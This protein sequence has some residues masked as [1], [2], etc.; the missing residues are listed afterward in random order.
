M[1]KIQFASGRQSLCALTLD[2]IAGNI[3]LPESTTYYFWLQARNDC[4]Y[5]LPGPVSNISIFENSGIKVTIPEQAL[6]SGENWLQYIILVADTNDIT[7]ANVLLVIEN[8]NLVFPYEINLTE[9]V[10]LETPRVLT[11]APTTNLVNGLVYSES[12]SGNIFFYSSL[13]NTWKRHY[14]GFNTGI[15]QTTEDL[16]LGCDTALIDIAPSRYIIN[17]DYPMNGQKGKSRKYWI[18]NNSSN[19]LEVD[20][21]LGITT[22]IQDQDV[23]SLFYGLFKV[24]FEG[25]FDRVTNQYVDDFTFS[26]INVEQSYES[27]MQ[28]LILEKELLP[29]QAFQ[30]SV[31]PEFN[32][33]ELG[34]AK[35]LLPADSSINLVPFLIPNT[36]R[37]TDLGILLGDSIVG[38]DS[39]LRRVYPAVGLSAFVD[40]G[41]T[42]IDGVLAKTTAPTLV[43]GFQSEQENQILAINSSGSLYSLSSGSTLRV[44]ERQR[45][46]VSTLA[47]E[48]KVSTF[49]SQI[50]ANTNP[51]ININITY[52]TLIRANYPDVISGSDKG[53]FNAEEIVFY[54]RKRES[55]D[56]TVI[57]TRRMGGFLPTNTISDSFEFLYEDAVI[58]TAALPSVDFGFYEPEQLLLEDVQL[59]NTIGGFFFDIAVSFKYN[60]TTLSSI[61]H[62]GNS[63]VELL[64]PLNEMADQL[65][66]WQKPVLTLSAMQNLPLSNLVNLAIYPVVETSKFYMYLANSTEVIDNVNIFGAT[67]DNGTGRFKSFS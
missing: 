28:N 19:E 36:G 46:L 60:G 4:G 50:E 29:Q 23:S 47:G 67:N 39:N 41:V 40:T 65:K 24:V 55:L 51:V 25:Y 64:K 7:Q 57:E 2:A 15:I 52:P 32:E 5:N 66:Y 58:Y 35:N 53:E 49:S 27:S 22:T 3:T 13:S 9:N 59:T 33:N 45:A 62:G 43:V 20:R 26:F 37:P 14:E 12:S 18:F 42:I 63:I 31:F 16:L 34:L 48:S 61:S 38:I 44:N 54:V 6:I 11:T 1:T 17:Y 8:E 10:H 30:F 56:G 21:Q